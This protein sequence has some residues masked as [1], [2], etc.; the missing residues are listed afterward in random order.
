[1]I[2]ENSDFVSKEKMRDL[3]SCWL[4]SEFNFNYDLRATPDK[5]SDS[6]E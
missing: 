3:A 2:K 6:E 4:E 5:F 1:M